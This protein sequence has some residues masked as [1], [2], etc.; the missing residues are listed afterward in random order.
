MLLEDLS[1]A[2]RGRA[3]IT[4]TIFGYKKAMKLVS[5]LYRDRCDLLYWLQAHMSFFG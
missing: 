2:L 1:G 4:N 3:A 5:G